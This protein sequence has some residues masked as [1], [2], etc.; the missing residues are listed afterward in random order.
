MSYILPFIGV[1]YGSEQAQAFWESR[2]EL[3][4]FR[5]GFIEAVEA[6]QAERALSGSAAPEQYF[7][8]VFK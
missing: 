2:I 1:T 7:E 4:V 3:G 8:E 6:L 5:S